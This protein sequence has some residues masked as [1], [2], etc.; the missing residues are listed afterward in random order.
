MYQ[1]PRAAVTTCL[2]LRWRK[3]RE[4]YSVTVP[5]ASGSKSWQGRAPSAGSREGPSMPSSQR[6]LLP[7][8]LGVPWFVNTSLRSPPP[9]S[10]GVLPSVS[11]CVSLLFL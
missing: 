3:T 10:R 9:S 7:A 5:E 8:V 1:F 6:L 4:V 2:R 11:V